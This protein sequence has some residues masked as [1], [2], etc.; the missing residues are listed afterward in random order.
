[1]SLYYFH[2]FPSLFFISNLVIIPALGLILIGGILII[3]LALLDILPAFIAKMYYYLIYT[4]NWIVDWVAQQENFLFKD[5]SF[6]WLMVITS[7]I[8]IIFTIRFF[9]KR[10]APRLIGFLTV[11]LFLQAVFVYEKRERLSANEFI[12]FQKSRNSIIAERNGKKLKVYHTLDSLSLSNDKVINQYKVGVGNSTVYMTDSVP[13]IYQFK[14]KNIL[15]VDSLGVYQ[16]NNLKPDI[17][18]LQQSPKINLV[19]LID[20]V[21]PQLIIADGSNYKSYVKKWRKTC[22]QKNTPFHHTGKKG[23]FI[24]YN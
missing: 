3:T 14:N 13:N 4:M 24:F 10:N 17:V 11:I 2:Q 8:L 5:I 22:E 21:N 18:I 1:L 23:A 15:I 20:S 7:Y 16:I 6:S 9:E 19:R 12:V